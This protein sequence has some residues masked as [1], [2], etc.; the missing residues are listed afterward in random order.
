MTDDKLND[1]LDQLLQQGIGDG[2]A[3]RGTFVAAAIPRMAG[4]IVSV[5][6]LLDDPVDGESE[7]VACQTTSYFVSVRS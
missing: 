1:L 4:L 2:V 5:A 7:D 6:S 3:Q